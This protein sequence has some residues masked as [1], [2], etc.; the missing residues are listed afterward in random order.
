V[1]LSR[2]CEMIDSS[3]FMMVRVSRV[4]GDVVAVD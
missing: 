4:V 3:I 1:A 2:G